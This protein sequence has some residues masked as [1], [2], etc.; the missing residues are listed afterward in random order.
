MKGNK[1]EILRLIEEKPR[2]VREI[3]A[4]MGISRNS[5]W[6]Y[7]WEMRGMGIIESKRGQRTGRTG[8]TEHTY[9]PVSA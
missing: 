2:T 7:I 8:K 5:V 6:F 1:L 9:H 4:A 3:M